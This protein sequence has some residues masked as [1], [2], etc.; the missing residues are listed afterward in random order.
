MFITKPKISRY[1]WHYKFWQWTFRNKIWKA[2]IPV[3]TSICAYCQR[4]FWIGGV[5]VLLHLLYYFFVSPIRLFYQRVVRHI[6]KVDYLATALIWAVFVAGVLAL[7]LEG[8]LIYLLFTV[9]GLLIGIGCIFI[10]YYIGK[11]IFKPINRY[12]DFN[13]QVYLRYYVP[14]YHLPEED[15]T[16]NDYLRPFWINFLFLAQPIVLLTIIYFVG[17]K[18]PFLQRLGG[19]LKLS[20][21]SFIALIA[22]YVILT[23][24]THSVLAKRHKKI[25]SKP[26]KKKP[27][28]KRSMFQSS[29]SRRLNSWLRKVVGNIADF[30]EILKIWTKSKKEKVCP[31]V[32]FVD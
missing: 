16:Y 21:W 6:T 10:L 30:I 26:K 3:Q 2:E 13:R 20:M 8:S 27:K 4:I 32:E 17:D 7:R 24:I 15:F 29:P 11:A 5:T 1:S 14:K 23:K 19:S 9:F 22:F 31:L 18:V 25:T 28:K 12:A